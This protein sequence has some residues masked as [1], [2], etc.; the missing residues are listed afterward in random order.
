MARFV[1]RSRIQAPAREVFDWHKRPGAFERLLPPWERVEVVD[2]TG[3]IGDGDRV[4]IR[5]RV[6][7]T[8]TRWV[9]EHRDYV[10]GEQFRDVQVKGPFKRWEHTHRVIADDSD[11]CTLED[12]ILYELPLGFVGR[13]LGRGL[14]E[15]KLRRMFEYRHAVTRADVLAHRAV[16]D[17]APQRILI[18]GSTGLI[19]SNL[20]PLLTTGG[21]EVIRLTRQGRGPDAHWNTATGSIDVKTPEP[22]DAVVHLAGESIA[23]RWTNARKQRIRESRIRGTQ[24]L[25]KWAANLDKPPRVFICAS[26]IG[27]YGNRGEETLN[28]HSSKGQ[29]F[30]AEVCAAWESAAMKA[31]SERTRVVPLRF[32]V[33]L[34]PRGGALA[35]MLT[36]FRLGGGGTIGGGRQI[37]S[38][39]SVD[40]AVGAVLHTMHRDELDGPVN[41]VS[42]HPVSNREFTEALGAVLRRPTVA[43]VPRA[44]ARLAFGEMAQELLLASQHVRPERL[45]QT[46][47]AFRHENLVDA[48]AHLLGTTNR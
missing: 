34:S 19:G 40:D 43:P 25:V 4:T 13:A 26:A 9:I 48:L 47:Y 31:R 33:V 29:G 30:L 28:E 17:L 3:G 11:G 20:A 16:G 38:W 27:Y 42:P 37:W 39:I 18:S 23:G 2:R 1:H 14:V 36:P 35:K 15:S 44:M 7:P 21:H 22:I 41:V 6:G 32:G 46:N 5:S 45:Q 10:E 12:D 24:Q 8:W